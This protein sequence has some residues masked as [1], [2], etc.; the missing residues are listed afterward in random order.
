[1]NGSADKNVKIR[2]NSLSTWLL[3]FSGALA[4][5]ALLN[6]IPWHS[7]IGTSGNGKHSLFD[8][9]RIGLTLGSPLW[10]ILAYKIIS[11]L[12]QHRL[13]AQ[14]ALYDRPMTIEEFYPDFDYLLLQSRIPILNRVEIRVSGDDAVINDS[15]ETLISPLSLRFENPRRLIVCFSALFRQ[16]FRPHPQ[17]FAAVLAH[18]LAHFQNRDADW[19]DGMKRLL[20]AVIALIAL[21][22]GMDMYITI[23]ADIGSNWDWRAVQASLAGKNFI[24]TEIILIAALFA[25]VRWITKWRE[26]LADRTAIAICG[27]A[28]LQSAERIIQG[29]SGISERPSPM[30]RQQALNLT[31]RETVLLGFTVNVISEY[32][33]GP[34]AYLGRF[35][36]QAP[37]ISQYLQP[38]AAA[39]MDFLG[40]LGFFAVLR[41]IAINAGQTPQKTIAISANLLLMGA[42]TGHLL[43]QVLPLLVT[44]VAMPVGYDYA[45]FHDPLKLV[46]D[47]FINESL[48]VSFT[49]L[50]AALGAFISFNRQSVWEGIAL[51]IVWVTMATLESTLF[52]EVAEGWLA[53]GIVLLFSLSLLWP[54]FSF[55]YSYHA[56]PW[57]P[58]IFLS[59]LF[60]LGYGDVNHLA[61]CSSQTAVRLADKGDVAGA[62]LAFQRAA[63]RAPLVADGWMQLAAM[64]ARKPERI[65]EAVN[66]AERAVNTP[67]TSAWETQFKTH[68]LTGD[69]RLSRRH[70]DDIAQALRH[71]AVAENLWYHNSRL[72]R[73]LAASMLFNEACALLLAKAEKKEAVI[74][75]LEAIVLNPNLAEGMA[76]D[77][78]LAELRLSEQPAPKPSTISILL[79]AKNASAPAVRNT[80][81]QRGIEDEELLRFLAYLVSQR[82]ARNPS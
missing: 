76:S 63:N 1:M 17:A 16:R 2:F 82:R 23:V 14:L 37:P 19:L 42:I 9:I 66:A 36:L 48:S 28:A 52:P 24:L 27:E 49:V 45:Y 80:A 73:E 59:V 58:M 6:I 32:G 54:R 12:Q 38:L 55:K 57:I 5:S 25:Y 31:W 10:I 34:F 4:L 81:K 72:P 56:L 35:L 77:P 78:D 44:S 68:I 33:A 40:F 71:Y 69:L 64:L 18:E 67:F 8:W 74:R 61:A 70:S 62:I 51:G 46:T 65:D 41:I 43:L 3:I 7:I 30:Q 22:W 53:L 29:N 79:E 20:V 60:W 13:K 11:T 75:L 39:L 15:G 47:G 26:A 50:L 21:A